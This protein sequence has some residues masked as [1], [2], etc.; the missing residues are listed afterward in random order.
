MTGFWPHHDWPAL[1]WH[2]MFW[3]YSSAGCASTLTSL[4]KCGWYSIHI[5]WMVE[6]RNQHIQGGSLHYLF[7]R[8]IYVGSSLVWNFI[9]WIHD[10]FMLVVHEIFRTMSEGFLWVIST[11]T[12]AHGK[13]FNIIVFLE[14]DVH[15]ATWC[16]WV[17]QPGDWGN[18]VWVFKFLKLFS[19]ESCSHEELRFKSCVYWKGRLLKIDFIF[20]LCSPIFLDGVFDDMIFL[21]NTYYIFTLDY[22]NI[23]EI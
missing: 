21:I 10:R 1:S 17:H 15:E 13:V 16:A 18:P 2:W 11:T 4:R 23:E 5:S 8:N 6:N 14:S 3:R 22:I 20:C 9:F 19:S 7:L 12:Q